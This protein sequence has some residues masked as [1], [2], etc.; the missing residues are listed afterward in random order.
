MPEDTPA[1]SSSGSMEEKPCSS[2]AADR[3]ERYGDTA[4]ECGEAFFLCGKSLLDLARMENSVLG[5]ALE[6][7]PEE[8]SEEGEK[9]DSSKIESADNLD[10]GTPVEPSP[11]KDDAGAPVEPSPKKDDAGAPVEPSPKKDEGGAPVE[12]SPKKDEGGASVEP[13]PKDSGVPAEPS[14]KEGGIVV[15]PSPKKVMNG[16]GKEVEAAKDES[17][18]DKDEN[19]D[20][21]GGKLV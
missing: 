18:E 14:S 15:E 9:L 1:P 19:M 10:G 21:D 8:S 2:S 7:V 6:G 11:K 20:E 16:E 12:P 5:N 3:A 13:S 17:C 4:D